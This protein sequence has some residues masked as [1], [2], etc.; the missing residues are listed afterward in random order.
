[1]SILSVLFHT[2]RGE[3]QQIIL[4]FTIFLGKEDGLCASQADTGKE[5]N[6]S[7]LGNKGGKIAI[8]F[9]F[10]SYQIHHLLM[11]ISCETGTYRT[12]SPS[13][14]QDFSVLSGPMSQLSNDK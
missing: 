10:I 5:A 6:S 2:E 12:A 3:A 7:I 14:V 9:C 1:M 4:Y 8:Y 13:H 11:G